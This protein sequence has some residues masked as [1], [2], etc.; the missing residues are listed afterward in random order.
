LEQSRSGE[1]FGLTL[2]HTK[3]H[4]IRAVLEGVIYNLSMVLLNLEKFAGK[5]EIIIASGGFTR[6]P[7]WRQMLAD[8]LNCPVA[9][10]DRQESSCFGAAILGLYALQYIANLEIITTMTQAKQQHF[11]IPENV[12]IYQKILPIYQS[13]LDKFQEEY[14]KLKE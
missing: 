5:S 4:L 13:L 10:P 7:L 14:V 6:S 8:I 2:N 11:P 12:E 3:D 9:I 1:F